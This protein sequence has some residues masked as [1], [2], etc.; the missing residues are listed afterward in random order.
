MVNNVVDHSGS[1]GVTVQVEREGHDVHV[2]VADRGIGIFR[3]IQEAFGLESE[4]AA[5]LELAKGKVTTDPERHTGEGIFFTARMFDAFALM[6]GG[7]SFLFEA[8]R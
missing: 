6:S 4:H 2:K 5:A 3:K 1:E 7:L 8:G